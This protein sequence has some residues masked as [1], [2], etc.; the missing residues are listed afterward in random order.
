MSLDWLI[1]GG[2]IHGVHIA[3]RL[4]G[5]AKVDPTTIRVVD[6]GERLLDRWLTCTATTGMTHLRSPA[7]HNIDVRPL[8]LLQ[9]AGKRRS[10]KPGLFMGRYKRPRLTLFNDHCEKVITDYGL[11]ALHVRARVVSCTVGP[12]RVVATLSS[13]EELSLIHI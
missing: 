6:P 7:V 8:S 12:D 4:I 5:E 2:G 10:R 11:D 1:I 3:A 9:Y 13:G